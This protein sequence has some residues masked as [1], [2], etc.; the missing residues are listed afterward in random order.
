VQLLVHV[1][2]MAAAL[3]I[4]S[5]QHAVNATATHPLDGFGKERYRHF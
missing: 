1:D 4:R 3:P 5:I 2:A